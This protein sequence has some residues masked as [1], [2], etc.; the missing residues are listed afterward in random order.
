MADLDAV[1]ASGKGGQEELQ[2]MVVEEDLVRGV[3]LGVGW[4]GRH[5]KGVYEM[6]VVE[7]H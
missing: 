4:E 7:S 2:M 1:A 3:K 5:E 6:A